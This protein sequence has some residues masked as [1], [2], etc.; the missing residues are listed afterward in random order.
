M[1]TEKSFTYCLVIFGFLLCVFVSGTDA[2]ERFRYD[3][4][5]DKSDEWYRGQEAK[6]IAENILSWQ[7]EYG[8]WPKNMNTSEERRTAEKS[9]LDGTFDNRATTDEMR[10][11]AH[12]FNATNDSVYSD[13]FIKSLELI[14]ESQYP[15]GGWPQHYPAGKGYARYITYNDDAMIRLMEMLADVISDPM[16]LFVSDDRI[17]KAKKAYEKGMQCIL[18]CQVKVN[19]K[20][21]VW[22]AQHDEITYEPR[23]ARSFELTSLSGGES[24]YILH[25]LMKQD[26]PSRDVVKA[27]EA[28]V[29]WYKDS[30]VE[31]IRLKWVDGKLRAVDD[32]EAKPIWGRFYEIETNRPF[33]CDR[34]GI[35]KYDYNRIDQER[36]TGYAWYG[37]W[38]EG[39]LDEYEKWK[40][41][42]ADLISDYDK[43]IIAV[44]GDSTVCEYKES[45]V[46]RGWG[47]FIQDYFADDSIKVV[48]LAKSGRSTKTFIEQGWWQKTLDLQPAYV[49]IQFGHNDSHE[50]GR[51]E[52]TDAE[53]TYPDFLRQYID[54][55]RQIGAI[56]V[57]VTPMYRRKFDDKG[58]IRDNLLPYADAMKKVALEKKVAVVDLNAASEKLY[59]K[60]G[61]QGSMELAN[62]ADDQTHF[63]EKGAKAM[64]LLVMEQLPEVEKSLKQYLSEGV[65][66][67]A[68]N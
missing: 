22:C 16:Y 54:Q 35:P 12:I 40:V 49:L 1:R 44:I 29:N 45:D 52:S 21:T 47:H 34:D 15:S 2:A 4:Y 31:G 60:L 53:T 6:S 42:W 56:P 19:G 57:L 68:K 17:D 37:Y 13:A 10:Y 24:A 46:R 23:P 27:I 30:K 5:S 7:D 11:I 26:K 51:N 50:P 38:G 39:V 33:F 67:N 36:S 3:K 8:A 28:G 59:L 20:L 14:F 48:N 41:K 18:K 66:Q 65:G 55:S 61:P 63:N 58:N 9:D 32:P 25:F 64:A 62:A 43:K